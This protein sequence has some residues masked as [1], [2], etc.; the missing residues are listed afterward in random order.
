MKGSAPSRKSSR[1]Y[2]RTHKCQFP[3]PALQVNNLQPPGFSYFWKSLDLN[4][5]FFF[6]CCTQRTT[7]CYSWCRSVSEARA[8]PQ[9]LPA[10]R[11][12]LMGVK[13]RD[14]CLVLLC[15][16]QTRQ[17]STFTGIPYLSCKE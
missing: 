12:L 9:P 7:Q 2:S 4:T 17:N 11:R 3:K 5:I 8:T 1:N 16:Q 10:P 6:Q 15:Q 13:R 14:P